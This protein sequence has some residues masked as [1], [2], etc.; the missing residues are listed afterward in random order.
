MLVALMLLY[1]TSIV[2]VLGGGGGGLLYVKLFGR[3]VHMKKVLPL[4]HHPFVL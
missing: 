1:T 4:G 2:C 3:E